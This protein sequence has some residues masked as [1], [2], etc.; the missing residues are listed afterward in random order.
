M[1]GHVFALQKIERR[2]PVSGLVIL[3]EPVG[4][5]AGSQVSIHFIQGGSYFL[6]ASCTNR[7]QLVVISLT[8]DFASSKSS[9]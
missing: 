1:G 8:W 7:P 3:V 5:W 2:H 4:I 9:S 6:D